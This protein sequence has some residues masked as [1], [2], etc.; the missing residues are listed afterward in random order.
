MASSSTII[1]KL[2]FLLALIGICN[3]VYCQIDTTKLIDQVVSLKSI[4]NHKLFWSE[5]YELD[6]TYRGKSTNDSIDMANL[7]KCSIYLNTFGY[8]SRK[9][10]GSKSAIISMVWIHNKYPQVDLLTFPIIMEGL[11]SKQI[12]ENDFKVYYLKSLYRRKYP[13][14]NNRELAI[15]QSLKMIKPRIQPPINLAE[16]ITTFYKEK[17]FLESKNETVGVWYSEVTFDTTNLD[18]KFKIRKVKKDAIKIFKDTK[19]DFYYQRLHNDGSHYPQKLEVVGENS[20]KFKLFEGSKYYF[21]IK[22]NGNLI[23]VYEDDEVENYTA[24]ESQ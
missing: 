19:S 13:D 20:T 6:Q 4:E 3:L 2:I 8:P 21:K 9:S 16:L 5:I 12:K 17:E 18:P 14:D 24:Q 7:I 23:I 1:Y 22:S 15:S 10:L 11:R